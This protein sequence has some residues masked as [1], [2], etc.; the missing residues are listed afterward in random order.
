M[1]LALVVVAVV[2]VVIVVSVVVVVALAFAFLFFLTFAFLVPDEVSVLVNFADGLVREARV[3]VGK[4][5]VYHLTCF[6][7]SMMRSNLR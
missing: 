1:L 6:W 4:Q 7:P 5:V 3:A 2:A